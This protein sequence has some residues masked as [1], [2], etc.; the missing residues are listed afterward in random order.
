MRRSRAAVL[1]L[2]LVLCLTTILTV[3]CDGAAG[4][5]VKVGV[6]YISP[7]DDGGWSTAH[8]RGVDAAI[9]NIGATKVELMELANV[10]DTDR[11]KTD[12]AIDQMVSAGCKIIFTTSFG[13][14]DATEAKAKQ[15]PDVKFEHCSG[16]KK[17]DNFDNYFGQIEQPRY[18]TGVI[19][20]LMTKSDKIGYVA[21]MPIP[22]VIR[23][24]DAFAL[25]VASVNPDAKVYVKWT[26][27]WFG[28]D[29]E[30]E[31]A[32]SL[33]NDGCDVLSQHQDSPAALKAAEEKGVFA[34]GYDNPMGTQAPKAYLTGPIWN[35]GAYYEKK[36]K[37]VMDKTWKVEEYWGG[38]KEGM[39][40]ID[41]MTA[42][43]PAEVKSKVEALI[44]AMKEKGND[45]IFKGPLKDQTGAVK[46][47]EGSTMSRDDQMG[48]S[49]FV[50]GVVG[51]IPAT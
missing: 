5:K 31:A 20:G 44:P 13:Y 3:G 7:T 12:A 43:V 39:V 48:M 47:A 22:E 33:L 15:Y 16:Y 18:L 37:A 23:G 46:V 10:P 30:K 9:A 34:F 27:T 38:M 6:L 14:M 35:W 40:D 26:L 4:G 21:A 19:A 1:A 25:G 50:E 11:Q 32:V 17:G 36:I 45:A 8:K 24:I 42:L 28:P 29:K 2:A 51:E 49:W 41:A